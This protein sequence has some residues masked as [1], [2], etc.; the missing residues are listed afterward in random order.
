MHFELMVAVKERVYT[1]FLTDRF[2]LSEY[3]WKHCP[4]LFSTVGIW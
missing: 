2:V 4:W 1:V 3:L